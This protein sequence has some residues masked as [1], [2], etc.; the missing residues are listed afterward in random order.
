VFFARL[1]QRVIHI[2]TAHTPSGV[3][4]DVDLRLRPSGA[5]GLLVSH[6]DAY[7]DYQ[8]SDAWT[9][10]HQALVRARPIA[11][12]PAVLQQFKV[13]RREIL[14]RRRDIGTLQRDVREMREKMRRSLLKVSPEQFDLKQSE[15][16]IVDIEFLV[17]YAVLA[18]A[19]Q[20]AAL[21]HW[22]DNIR[23]LDE[24]G[25]AGRLLV[26]DVHILQN[27]YRTYR[28][29]QHKLTLRGAPAIVDAEEYT[30]LRTHVRRVWS[31]LLDDMHEP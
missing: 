24:L 27:A 20:C 25:H 9:W 23:L 4:Y 10:E 19:H 3:L 31:T 14:G 6:I 12:D 21:L 28:A 7:A 29:H 5:S 13:L 26:A 2:L 1:G 18:W 22:P 16:G 30:E 15:G 8:R 11:G 17:Q